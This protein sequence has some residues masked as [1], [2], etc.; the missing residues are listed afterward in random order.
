MK[1]YKTLIKKSNNIELWDPPFYTEIIEKVDSKTFK[2]IL[3]HKYYFFDN[4]LR[5]K[6]YIFIE[7][8]RKRVM[9][10]SKRKKYIISKLFQL[11]KN[12]CQS[13]LMVKNNS[14]H[15]FIYSTNE[16]LYN[17][18]LKYESILFKAMG[19]EKL[20]KTIR[21]TIENNN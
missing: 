12:G 19:C 13:I 8:D 6:P 9:S 1:K 5:E 20:G 15:S 14:N 21:H 18:Y 4:D 17:I 3:F 7:D 10:L 2:K 16:E 11:K